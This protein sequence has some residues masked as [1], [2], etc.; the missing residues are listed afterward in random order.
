MNR[1]SFLDLYSRE[2]HFDKIDIRSKI[3]YP[4]LL[5]SSLSDFFSNVTHQLEEIVENVT[6]ATGRKMD[7]TNYTFFV[8]KSKKETGKSI[9][10]SMILKNLLGSMLNLIKVCKKY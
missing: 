1:S 2:N 8:Y 9:S 5:N 6:V 7:E 4:K 10:N 3:L